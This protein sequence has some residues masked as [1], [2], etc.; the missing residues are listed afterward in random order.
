MTRHHRL[1]QGCDRVIR[2]T[3][4]SPPFLTGFPS[5]VDNEGGLAPACLKA[6]AIYNGE[7]VKTCQPARPLPCPETSGFSNVH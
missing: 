3:A 5:S 4:E 2:Q 6:D 7:G 1:Y